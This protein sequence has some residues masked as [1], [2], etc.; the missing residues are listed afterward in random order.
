MKYINPEYQK[1][2]KI[3]ELRELFKNAK[4]YP[5]LVL[6]DFLVEDK[7]N[8][9]F[10]QFP[11]IEK[12]KIHWNGLNEYKSEGSNFTDFHQNFSELKEEIRSQDFQGW[13]AKVTGIENTQVT[14]DKLGCGLHQGKNGSFLDPHVDF[15][16]HHLKNLYRR[17]NLLIYLNKNWK[18]EY[19][20]KLELWNEDMSQC[21]KKVEVIFNRCVIFETS[22]ISYHGYSKI[23]VPEGVTRKSFYSYFYTENPG[24]QAGYHDTT[25]KAKPED[26][27]F[28]K[29]QVAVKENVKNSTKKLLKKLG[30][31]F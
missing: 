3:E 18:D 30:V 16:M 13:F 5:H 25:F 14:D 26:N 8:I 15:N 20:G 31:K 28:K 2:E 7:A 22:N 23:T 21:E 27:T 6:D 4:P 24:K 11:P 12:L 1:P 10:D 17:S 29:A 9:L 19:G